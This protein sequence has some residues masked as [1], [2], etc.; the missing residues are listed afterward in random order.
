MPKESPTLRIT[1]LDISKLVAQ[2]SEQDPYETSMLKTLKS[3]VLEIDGHKEVVPLREGDHLELG[4]F[5]YP[6]AHQRD[7]TPYDAFQ[8]G[9]SR[10]HA[11]IHVQSNRL[12]LVD[13]DSS[14]GTYVGGERL[15]PAQPR[16][17]QNGDEIL[18]GRL[19]VIIYF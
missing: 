19:T 17:L 1:N 3:V 12:Y 9:I 11:D 16:L 15:L 18:L 4:R 5:E 6:E 2:Q 10:R 8:H 13:L 14:N 7:L